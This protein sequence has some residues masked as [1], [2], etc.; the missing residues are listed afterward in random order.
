ML[1]YPP[2][3]SSMLSSMVKRN[4]GAA[5]CI[6]R[7][8]GCTPSPG[9]NP[10]ILL[11]TK[12]SSERQQMTYKAHVS[13]LWEWSIG[14]NG[15]RCADRKPRITKMWRRW[16]S[17]M[18][19]KNPR[20]RMRAGFRCLRRCPYRRHRRYQNRYSRPAFAQGHNNITRNCIGLYA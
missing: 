20:Y 16:G 2:S 18:L 7:G 9:G 5:P 14:E 11:R 12:L 4:S 15:Y 6:L 13:F 8:I 3:F 19:E 17:S 10:G 1:R